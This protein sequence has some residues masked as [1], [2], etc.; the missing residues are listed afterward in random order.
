MNDKPTV[1]VAMSG[2]VDSSVAAALLKQQGYQ[3]IGATLRLRPCTDE[4]NA[5]WCCSRGAE[6]QSRAVA[7]VLDIPH[8]VIDASDVFEMEILRPAWE[9]YDCGRTPSPC[10]RCNNR[11]K[12]KMLMDLGKKLGAARVATGHYARIKQ[13][14]NGLRLLRGKDPTKDQSY[15]LFSLP[16]EYLRAALFPL[17]DLLKTEVRKLA[18]KFQFANADRKESQDACFSY[19]EN[20]F[21]EALRIRFNAVSRPGSVLNMQGE[22]IGNHQGIHL[23]T[24]GQRKGL[25]IAMGK[26]AYVARID[27]DK[28]RVYLTDNPKDLACKALVATGLTWTGGAEPSFP[29]QCEAQIRYRHRPAKAEAFVDDTGALCV[30]FNIPETAAAPGQAVVLYDGDQVLGGGWID[31]TELPKDAGH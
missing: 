9:E 14:E 8:Y 23:Y 6:E 3:V 16:Q 13:T 17:G 11:I 29:I 21:A 7:G 27:G 2:G 1:I 22:R 28:D 24:V 20:G 12:F 26:R 10:I 18:K 4:D 19:G 25:R 30:R 5:K 31:R 15:F